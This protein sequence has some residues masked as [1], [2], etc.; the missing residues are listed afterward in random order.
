MLCGLWDLSSLTR[1]WFCLHRKHSILTTGPPGKSKDH[2][3]RFTAF[4][5]VSD[6]T[7]VDLFLCYQFH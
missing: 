5:P 2:F 1:D 7:Y 4:P 3:L 6:Y